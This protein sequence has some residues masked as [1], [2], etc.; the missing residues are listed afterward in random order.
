MNRNHPVVLSFSG[1]DPSGGA[2]IQADIE[3]L[4]S[5]HCHPCSVITA[6]TEQDT[7]N[8][9]RLIPLPPEDILAQARRLLHD[10]PVAVIKI[11]LLGHVETA[12]IIGEILLQYPKIPV[13]LDPVLA[14]GGGA[15]LASG[16]LIQAILDLLP[17]CTIVTPNSEE[18]RKLMPDSGILEQ[19]GID[20]SALGCNYV[21]ITGTHEQTAAVSNHLFQKGRCIETYDWNRLPESYHGSGCTLAASIAALLAQGL[22]PGNAIQEAQEYTWNSLAA[23]YRPGREQYVPNRLYWMHEE[24]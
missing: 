16:G 12:Q 23:G 2:G 1:H 11:G 20:L 8:V 17:L 14:A 3:A 19:C 22:D 6:L 24:L 5:H 4:I 13:V 21:L 10:M 18:A 9:H 7:G 15:S